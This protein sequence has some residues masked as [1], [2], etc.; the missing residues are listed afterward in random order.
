MDKRHVLITG[1]SRGIGAAMVRAFSKNG[2]LVAFTYLKSEEKAR[3]L[4]KETGAAAFLCD[5]RSEKD[6][7]RLT[8]TF[9]CRY[10][11]LDVL[12]SNAGTSSAGLLEETPP[13]VWDDLFA[14][15]VRGAYLITRAFLP[16]LRE[17]SGS[18]LYVS[19]MW[20]QVGG[21]C[22]AA[23]SAA[24]AAL[25]GLTKA[26]AKEAAPAV[27][28]NCVAPGVIDTDMM[29]S[30]SRSDKDALAEETPLNRLGKPCEVADAALFLCSDA[31]S[32]IT[33]QVLSVNGGLVI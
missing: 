23:Y 22:E 30:F 27:R 20:G 25:I 18:L 10:H 7:A 28:V 5:A 17:K 32:F 4:S 2:D 33:G 3:A 9:L 24:K 12:I 11:T 13:D 16:A 21:S 6:I 31:A 14:V 8:Q 15:H 26:L 19:S 1:G 29:A